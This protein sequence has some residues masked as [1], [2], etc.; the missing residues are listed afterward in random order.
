MTT[1]DGFAIAGLAGAAAVVAAGF[2]VLRGKRRPRENTVPIGDTRMLDSD[3]LTAGAERYENLVVQTPASVE[4]T[5]A[6]GVA[7]QRMGD[8]AAALFFY[9][10]AIDV[11]QAEY[12]INDM[13]RRGPS[14]ADQ[15]PIDR[16]LSTLALIREQ[17]PA[18]PIT[19]SV[20]E[21]T[22]RLRTI[23]TKCKV[24]GHDPAVYVEA[25]DFLSR[26]APDVHIRRSATA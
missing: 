10:K 14:A 5:T 4:A 17:R 6:A 15:P 20:L 13:R 25:L 8:V 1:M 16:F 21:V 22:H 7:R 19:T 2:T 23:S 3:W 11:M 9:Q 18:A 12:V 26:I 24:E